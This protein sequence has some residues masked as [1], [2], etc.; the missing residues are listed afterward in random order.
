MKLLTKELQYLFE[1]VGK[2]DELKDPVVVAKYFAPG[3]SATWYATE[4][5]PDNGVFFGYVTGLGQNEFGYFA[6]EELKELKAPPFDLAVERDWDFEPVPISMLV[7]EIAERLGKKY[8]KNQPDNTVYHIHDERSET[9]DYFLGWDTSTREFVLDGCYKVKDG[10]RHLVKKYEYFEGLRKIKADLKK[11]GEFSLRPYY[12]GMPF[13]STVK[14]PVLAMFSH[15][16]GKMNIDADKLF[17]SAYPE[18]NIESRV[19]TEKA[20]WQSIEFPTK[21]MDVDYDCLMNSLRDIN[22][23]HLVTALS[24][25]EQRFKIE[26]LKNTI[27]QMEQQTQ[28]KIKPKL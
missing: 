26:G 25:T 13:D 6:L 8:D 17:K 12:L 27:Q 18:L 2:Q 11:F 5:I 4:Y 22:Y 15:Y 3:H 21:W 24:E 19:I 16:C 1:K 14:I 20:E 7:P 9:C 23:P 10:I 28:Q